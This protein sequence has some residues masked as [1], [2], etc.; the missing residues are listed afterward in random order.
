MK[1]FELAVLVNAQ[2]HNLG[3][4]HAAVTIVEYGD[5]ECPNCKQAAPAMKMLLERF[6]GRV[7]LVWRQFPLEEVHPRALQA[8]LASEA[9]AG[10][11]KFWPLHDLLSRTS[12]TSMPRICAGTRK[13]SSSTC[14]ATTLTWPTRSTCSACARTSRARR[15]AACAARRRSS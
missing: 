2:D 11:G 14:A 13:A 1:R 10:Q 7:R 9:A 3:P 12:A 8:A 15:R 6:V 5:F 4:S